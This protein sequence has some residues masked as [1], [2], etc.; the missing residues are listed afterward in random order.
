[1]FDHVGIVFKDLKSSGA[2]YRKVLEQIGIRLL[3]D[4][5]RPDNSGWLVFGIDPSEAP[6]F[7]VGAGRRSFWTASSA[8]ARSPALIAFRV[9]SRDAVDRFH[10]AGLA[11]GASNNGDPGVRRGRYYSAFLIDLDGNNIEAG[12][13]D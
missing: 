12:V 8:P 7:V 5:T 1:M 13:Y 6:F 9:P 4:H 2:F 3:E 10:A 11:A